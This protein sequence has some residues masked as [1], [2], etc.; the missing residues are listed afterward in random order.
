MK[1][2]RQAVWDLP[3]RLMHWGLVV[4]VGVAWF[5][6]EE[7]LRRHVWAGYAAL[8]IVALRVVWGAIGSR[9]AR[10][11]D[12]MRPPR[13][14]FA[15]VMALRARS[16]ERYLGHNPLGGWMIA[17][18]LLDLV[19]VCVSGWMYTLD[20]FWGL[21]WLEW[22]HRVSAWALIALIVLHVGG[23]IFSSRRHRENLIV[24]MITGWKKRS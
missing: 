18:L 17:V 15:Y 22:S 14:V 11:G 21:A 23:V 20:A 10:F 24:S 13:A 16:E 7:T 1:A 8:L 9:H 12:F 2:D 4:A 6:G 19:L 3:V 5:S